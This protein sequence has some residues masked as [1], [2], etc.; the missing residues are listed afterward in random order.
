MDE[1]SAPDRPVPAQP[2][3]APDGVTDRT[4]LA[5]AVG[6]VMALVPCTAATARRILANTA[7]SARTSTLELSVAVLALRTR[8]PVDPLL[9]ALLGLEISRAQT[10]PVGGAP[11]AGA[12]PRV[13]R[14]QL[15]RLRAARRRTLA[16]PHDPAQRAELDDAAYALCL[17]TGQRNAHAALLAA[18]AHLAAQRP[19]RPRPDR[20]ERHPGYGDGG[21]GPLVCS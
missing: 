19:V 16:A 21:D 14:E 7:R 2:R 13:L 8:A 15:S 1:M 20:P 6:V 3:S 11:A 12:Q 9:E 10:P 4:A 17:L 18:E 5:R